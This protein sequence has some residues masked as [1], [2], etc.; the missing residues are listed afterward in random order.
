MERNRYIKEIFYDRRNKAL[1]RIEQS[2]QSSLAGRCSLCFY[3]TILPYPV[4]SKCYNINKTLTGECLHIFR[5]DRS[6]I[7]F[8][9]IKCSSLFLYSYVSAR[10]R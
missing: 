5:D 7:I 6:D 8:R 10:G 1:L 3:L 2:N 9:Y 4:Y